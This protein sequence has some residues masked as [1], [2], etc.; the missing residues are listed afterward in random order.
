MPEM[1]E[2]RSI[3]VVQTAKVGGA[4]Y[5]IVAAVIG[6]CFA[7]VTLV[8]GHPGRAFLALVGIPIFYAVVAFVFTA[9][10]CLLY[11]EIARRIGG[12]EIELA[13]R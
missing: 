7:L 3:S 4:I 11:N 13:E 8:R 6:I 2:I 5:L 10:F 1:Q 9:V 12:I